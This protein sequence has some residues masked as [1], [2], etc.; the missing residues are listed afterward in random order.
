[1]SEIKST[2]D[3]LRDEIQELKRQL[4]QRNAQPASG[5]S[6]ATLLIIGCV[7]IA[8][9]VT[10]FFMGY[11]P[12]HRREEVLAAESKVASQNLP[13]VTVTKVTRSAKESQMVLPGNIQ[14]VTEAPVFGSRILNARSTGSPGLGARGVSVNSSG[15]STGSGIPGTR[16]IP[17]R[18]HLPG[19]A[20]RTSLSIGQT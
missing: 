19:P 2:E 17:H 10:G 4:N 1:M 13:V 6:A 20:E 9:I 15:Y 8:L 3:R 7:L 18:G 12:R 14:A 16:V 11:L 5:P